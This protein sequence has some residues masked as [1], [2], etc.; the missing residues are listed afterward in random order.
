MR[1]AAVVLALV[2][3]LAVAATAQADDVTG[4]ELRSLA[5]RAAHDPAA[6]ARLA[7]IDH[8]NGR[9]VDVARALR[10]AT[11]AELAARLQTLSSRPLRAATR[12]DARRDAERVLA[13]H[14]FHE[15]A[16]PRPLHGALAWIGRRLQPLGEPFTWLAA[17][18]GGSDI[19][20]TILGIGVA[21]AAALLAFLTARRR[22]AAAELLYFP[23]I[24]AAGLPASPAELER[25]AVV[26]ERDGDFEGAVRLRFRAGLFGLDRAH[27][28]RY[29]ASLTT[30]ELARSL[31]SD[32]FDDIA[33]D[34]DEIVYGGRPAVEADARAAR[35]GWQRVLDRVRGRSGA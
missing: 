7:R 23:D 20:L 16:L 25:L 8:V 33:H 1:T 17:K 12:Q 28:I 18:L 24:D 2:A 26:R 22:A 5:E 14:R 30:A 15:Q 4:A 13:Q 11:G 32:D 10:G 3:V 29:R 34:F 31:R 35:E 19:A 21:L 27:A 6:R 9:P